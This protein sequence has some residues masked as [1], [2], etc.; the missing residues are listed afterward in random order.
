MCDDYDNA[1]G[2]PADVFDRPRD[3]LDSSFDVEQQR[4]ILRSW[5]DQVEKRQIA[6]TEGMSRPA[7]AE[8][9]AALLAEIADAL[10]VL[11]N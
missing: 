8:D 7:G 9:C 6:T 3:V 1:M 11:T 10:R 4:N 5:E 2:D